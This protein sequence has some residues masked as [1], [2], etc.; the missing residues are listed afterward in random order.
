M[1]F[2]FLLSLVLLLTAC[3]GSTQPVPGAHPQMILFGGLVY[4]QQDGVVEEAIALQDGRVLAVGSTADMMELA[5]DGTLFVD[6]DGKAVYP[7]FADAHA[8]LVGIGTAAVRL[9]LVG[10]TSYEEVIART[11]ER[12]KTMPAG[13]WLVGR[14][15]DQ[16][17]W[18]R[19]ASGTHELPTHMALSEA[20]PDRPVVLVR[21]DGHALLTNAAAMQAA[22]VDGETKEPEGGRIWRLTSGALSGVFV[23]TAEDLISVAMPGTTVAAAREAIL[24]ATQSLHE[25][26]ITQFHDAGVGLVTLGILEEL[27][28]ADQLQL[29]LHEMLHGSDDALLTRYFANGPVH[30]YQ[31]K[32]TLAVRAIKL[33]ADGALG[34][35]GAA[36]LEPYSD[37]HF[38][39]GLI[40]TPEEKMKSVCQSAIESGFQVCT[41]AIG[42]RGVRATLDTYEWAMSATKNE[43]A[44]LRFRVEHAQIVHGEDIPRFAE[45]GV[46][47][48]M[49]AQHQTSDM[50]WVEE[51]VGGERIRGAYAWRSFLKEGSIIPGGSDAPVERLDVVAQFKAAVTRQT[52]EGQ[53]KGGWYPEQNMTRQEA[54]N[55]LTIWPAHSAFREHDLGRLTPG[56]RADLVVFDGDLMTTDAD[57]LQNCH[58]VMTVFA[59]EV[60]WSAESELPKDQ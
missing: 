28:G 40:L 45:L 8:H 34:S 53:P 1:R 59:G 2:A 3:T 42:D 46:I 18:P 36:L 19:S 44:D 7:G 26:G 49:Q 41:H 6:L 30:D 39:N 20:I 24:V 31:G 33:Y 10:T 9:D 57:S 17:D 50:P 58:P 55:M 13:E 12:S 35:R 60:V 51:R 22:R 47:P 5:D 38:H 27:A 21:V 43:N 29:R 56:Y 4:T 32:G 14:G 37:E 48:S 54:L 23:D 16:N 25:Q 52:L 11:V 15:W